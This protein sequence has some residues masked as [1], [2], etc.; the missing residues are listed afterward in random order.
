LSNLPEELGYSSLR[1]NL[2][3]LIKDNANSVVFLTVPQCRL[4]LLKSANVQPETLDARLN[5]LLYK[6]I[7]NALSAIKKTDRRILVDK[8][9]TENKTPQLK[10]YY[11]TLC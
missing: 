3:D 2:R 6:R 11:L 9:I 7:H 4:L 8:T 1:I 5:K 10:I